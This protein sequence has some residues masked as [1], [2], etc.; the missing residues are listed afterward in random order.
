M[1]RTTVLKQAQRSRIP[2][3]VAKDSSVLYVAKTNPDHLIFLL[4][5][6]YALDYHPWLRKLILRTLAVLEISWK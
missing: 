4:K 5:H 2:F 6:P 1:D 3:G